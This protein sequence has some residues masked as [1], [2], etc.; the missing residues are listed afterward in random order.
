MA[1]TH[2]ANSQSRYDPPGSTAH[3][4]LQNGAPVDVSIDWDA[5]SISE[6]D[7]DARR[8]TLF[9]KDLD[10][11]WIDVYTPERVQSDKTTL[12]GLQNAHSTSEIE[13]LGQCNVPIYRVS[14]V[15]NLTQMLDGRMAS[16]REERLDFCFPR[17]YMVRQKNSW[18]RLYTSQDLLE[19]LL[20]PLTAENKSLPNILSFGVKT[21]DIDIGGPQLGYCPLSRS[22]EDRRLG[23]QDYDCGY[24]LKYIEPARKPRQHWSWS[25][26]QSSIL[27]NGRLQKWT[28]IS[29][30]TSMQLQLHRHVRRLEV[31]QICNSF[32]VHILFVGAAMTY[33]KPYLAYLTKETNE[34]VNRL[35]ATEFDDEV[36]NLLTV[37]DRQQFRLIED[38]I[39]DMFAMLDS[40]IDIVSSLEEKYHIFYLGCA[41]V[42]L[43]MIK[44]DQNAFMF[45]EQSRKLKLIRKQL[46]ALHQRVQ[47]S[48]QLLSS[49]LDLENGRSLR[50]LAE[51]SRTENIAMRKLS[52]KAQTDGAAV[53]VITII[54]MIYLPTTVVTNFFS[55]SFV[56][57]GSSSASDTIAVAPNW[58]IL[59][60]VSLPLTVLTF[61]AWWIL[62]HMQQCMDQMRRGIR[63]LLESFQVSQETPNP[64][65]PGAKE[66][67]EQMTV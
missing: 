23:H 57:S 65:G 67:V 5:P 12:C 4:S 35:I 44:S 31:G 53:K 60:A 46:E 21:E 41:S 32:T 18:S 6:A 59:V 51:E 36:F 43:E 17:F 9:E 10:R 55:T 64:S 56:Y 24:T 3:L 45:H 61:A 2:T 27:Y 25:E 40:T 34:Q 63:Y 16:S 62:Q 48:V 37:E 1:D 15:D 39:T 47:S 52:E 7:F 42:S 33:W 30:S 58:W 22:S 49:L 26:R 29:P 54:T 8:S 11:C 14:D 19:C 13:Y 50:K 20:G 66:Q 28:L 38:R